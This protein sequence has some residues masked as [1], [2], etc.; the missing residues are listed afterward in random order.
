[1]SQYNITRFV[2]Y[3][4]RLGLSSD[5]T[6]VVVVVVVVNKYGLGGSKVYS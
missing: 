6:V 1:M 4:M 5:Y 3:V 2:K